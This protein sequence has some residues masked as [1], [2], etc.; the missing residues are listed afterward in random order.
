MSPQQRGYLDEFC[1]KIKREEGKLNIRFSLNNLD[2]RN[3][4]NA[5]G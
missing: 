5:N 3:I 4:T 2:L 1:T